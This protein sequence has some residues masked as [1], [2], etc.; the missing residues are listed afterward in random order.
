VIEESRFAPELSPLEVVVVAYQ[1][2][3]PGGEIGLVAAS[4]RD[5]Y[6]TLVFSLEAGSEV[7]DIEPGRGVLTAGPRLVAGSYRLNVSATDGKFTSYTSVT[8]RVVPLWDD[9]LQNS[10][11]IRYGNN[12]FKLVKL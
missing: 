1:E 5:P 11:S 10:V 7:F 12:L 2:R 8:V 9:M 3:W 6:D 4:D